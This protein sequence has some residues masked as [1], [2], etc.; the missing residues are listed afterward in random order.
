[1]SQLNK[2]IAIIGTVGVPANYGGFET[3][4][5]NL[6]NKTTDAINYTVF[7]SSKAYPNKQKVY[8]HAEL[9]YIPLR[10]NGVQSILYDILSIFIA[11]KK[12]DC[13][14]ILGVSGCFILPLIKL[15]SNRTI[16]VNI[17]GLEHR[18]DK[19]RY[20]IRKFLKW[21]ESI[22]VRY[23]DIIVADN[24]AIQDYVDEEYGRSAE[25][26]AY[27]GDHVIV[28][29]DQ[30]NEDYYFALCRIEP[31]NNIHVILT[32]FENSN[33]NLVFVGNWD[34]SEYGITLKKKYA[35]ISNIKLL[36]PIYDPKQ[37]GALRSSCK[38]YIHGHSA[39]GTN[40]SLVE[41]MFF[42][43]P[44]IAF[45]VAYN[46]ETTENKAVY[47]KDASHL[48]S[49]INSTITEDAEANARAMLEIANRRYKWEI[50][51][52]QYESLYW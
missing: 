14:L 52:K 7:C 8:K 46:R 24:K 21:S 51:T 9:Y 30:K 16:I 48:C 27:G 42:N 47:F 20:S 29:V 17:D 50:I 28:S 37:L 5:E 40:P 2:K 45:D 41:S 4:V 36:D 11:L 18:R 3:L 38:C 22:A 13:L 15:F 6:L 44:I 34:N 25:L 19:W 1:M 10:A 12:H 35:K 43:K 49:I 33:H 31:E 32:A 26:I 23:A 39:G